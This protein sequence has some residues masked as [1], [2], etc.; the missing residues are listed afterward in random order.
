MYKLQLYLAASCSFASLAAVEEETDR[1]IKLFRVPTCATTYHWLWH[2]LVA[3]LLLPR[4]IN[5]RRVLL[6]LFSFL[7][8]DKVLPRRS[9]AKQRPF[10]YYHRWHR[11]NPPHDARDKLGGAFFPE[12]RLCFTSFHSA[13][14]QLSHYYTHI[15]PKCIKRREA[16]RERKCLSQWVKA[17]AEN[18]ADLDASWEASVFVEAPVDGDSWIEVINDFCNKHVVCCQSAVA[19]EVI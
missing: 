8:C 3:A 10:V 16:I 17:T 6:A 14:L 7:L 4:I 12:E 15:K 2:F 18:F 5:V 13:T 1:L 9:F 19:V 11:T